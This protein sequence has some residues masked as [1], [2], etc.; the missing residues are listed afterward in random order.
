MRNKILML[1]AL[2]STMVRCSS[3]SATAQISM[4][5]FANSVND[6]KAVPTK[7]N[8]AEKIKIKNTHLSDVQYFKNQGINPKTYGIY[9][10]KRG[11]HKRTNI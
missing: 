9:F 10:V 3:S 11:T 2:A 7:V 4:A 6:L 5:E 8:P 1:F